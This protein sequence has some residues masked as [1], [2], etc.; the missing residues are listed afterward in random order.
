MTACVTNVSI[1]WVAV[2]VPPCTSMAEQ[3][4][5]ASSVVIK[6]HTLMLYCTPS[7]ILNPAHIP[8]LP[9]L[10]SPHLIDGETEVQRGT[11]NVLRYQVS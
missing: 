7:W 4:Q 9:I 6:A 5:I 3:A 11:V 2:I 1:C 10:T 8:H